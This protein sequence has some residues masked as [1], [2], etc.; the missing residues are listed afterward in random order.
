MRSFG[1]AFPISQVMVF[2]MW[3]GISLRCEPFLVLLVHVL[4]PDSVVRN[5]INLVV[6]FGS[7]YSRGW[8]RCGLGRRISASRH[9]GVR[10]W[11]LHGPACFGYSGG[12]SCAVLTDVSCSVAT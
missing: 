6:A 4:G 2:F 11:L 8:C 7:V 10:S 12:L 3:L 5:L 1:G 9:L